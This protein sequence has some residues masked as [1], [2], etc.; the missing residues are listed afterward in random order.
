MKR[1]E[2]EFINAMTAASLKSEVKKKRTDSEQRLVRIDRE[3]LKRLESIAAKEGAG[4]QVSQSGPFGHEE[5]CDCGDDCI[6]ALSLQDRCCGAG[7][8]R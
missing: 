1:E 4:L 8:R 3:R 7:S 6:P 5:L 2:I